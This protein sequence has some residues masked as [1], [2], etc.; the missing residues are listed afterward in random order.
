MCIGHKLE[1][2]SYTEKSYELNTFIRF[3]FL[4]GRVFEVYI[5]R[6]NGFNIHGKYYESE[7]SFLWDTSSRKFYTLANYQSYWI[8]EQRTHLFG[9]RF[10]WQDVNECWIYFRSVQ[11]EET[12]EETGFCLKLGKHQ[13]LLINNKTPLKTIDL[14]LQSTSS[15][16][17]LLFNHDETPLRTNDLAFSST[18]CQLEFRF[19]HTGSRETHWQVLIRIHRLKLNAS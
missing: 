8:P 10:V 12:Y 1:Q 13:L 19:S 15:M 9:N 18:T 14:A 16:H 4:Y 7:C 2:S 3:P 5:L 11:V 6:E 17:R